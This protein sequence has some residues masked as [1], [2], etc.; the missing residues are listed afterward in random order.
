MTLN[1]SIKQS[2]QSFVV[3][4][5]TFHKETLVLRERTDIASAIS[6]SVSGLNNIRHPNVIYYIIAS[7][8]CKQC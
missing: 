3:R 6:L 2:I 7:I 4:F 1:K 5:S 8:K